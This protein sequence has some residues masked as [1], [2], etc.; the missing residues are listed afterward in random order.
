MLKRGSTTARIAVLTL[1]VLATAVV[2]AVI[3]GHRGWFDVGVYYGTV[4]HWIDTGQIYDYVRP[5]TVYGFTYPPFAAV[6]MLP[7]RLFGWH[8]AVAVSV[9]LS[10]AATALLLYWLV[11]PIARR[12]DW[13]RWYAFGL[14]ACLCALTNPVRDTFSFG[15]VN[16]LL[17]AL[18]FTDRQ[19]VG[20]RWSFLVGIGTGLAA[21]IK[22]TPA[23][24]IVHL[25]ITRQWRAAATATATALAATG[26]G[27]LIGPQVSR[28]FWTATLWDTDRVGGFANMSNQ[29]LQ[30]LIAR[31]G[32]QLPGRSLWVAASLAVLAVWAYRLRRADRAHDS[33]AAYSLTGLACCLVSPIT[34]VHHLVWMLPGLVVLADAVLNV[35]RT[36]RRRVLLTATW[37]IQLVVCSGMVWLWRPDGRSLG[38]LLGGSA[39]VLV[40]VALLIAMPIRQRPEEPAAEPASVARTAVLVPLPAEAAPASAAAPGGL[41]TPDG[42]DRP[43]RPGKRPAAVG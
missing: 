42:S 8:P 10:A 43:R 25:L 34:W 27:F 39:Y 14:A 9:A 29:S 7:M 2:L 38:T 12:R 20:S 37:L 19:L 13:C 33:L 28:Q 5:G 30:G 11:D 36:A 16:L 23:L 24:F 26:V 17:V 41:G 40:T 3:P 31:L 6:C 15:Q 1:A 18:V 4:R 35:R 21:A 32:P 22:L